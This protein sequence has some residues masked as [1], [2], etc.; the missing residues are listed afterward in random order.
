MLFIAPEYE[1]ESAVICTDPVLDPT[2][3]VRIRTLHIFF[4]P[5]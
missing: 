5:N 3:S 4:N 2:L 1:S